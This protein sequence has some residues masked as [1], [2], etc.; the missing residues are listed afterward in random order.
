MLRETIVLRCI[1]INILVGLLSVFLG[2]ISLSTLV[3]SNVILDALVR[4]QGATVM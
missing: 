4:Q 2:T 3:H 1:T